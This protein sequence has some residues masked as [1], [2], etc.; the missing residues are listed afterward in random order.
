V[1]R[2]VFG[3][4]LAVATL[5]WVGPAEL[6][7]QIVA[8]ERGLVRQTIDG[9][10]IEIDYGRPSA[11]GRDRL[12]GG[13]VPWGLSWTPGANQSTTISFSKPVDLDGVPVDAG[14]YSVWVEVNE[15]PPW[16]LLLHPDTMLFH[17]AH[18]PAEE[19]SYVVD[20]AP[21]T[22][23]VFMETLLFSFPVVRA[24][25]A[26]L[27]L[28][29]GGTVLPV[30]VAVES[31]VT[32]RVSEEEGRALEGE[33]EFAGSPEDPPMRLDFAWDPASGELRGEWDQGSGAYD[34]VM[35]R[36]A[37]GIYQLGLVVGDRLGSVVEVW[38]FEFL[39]FRNG[40][41]QAFEVRDL[42]DELRF[43]GRR[44]GR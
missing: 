29:W 12:F 7:A 40:R 1:G 43:E 4:A 17:T 10:V 11:R 14:V 34:V 8:S 42:G 32:L 6:G 27:Q 23:S 41:A 33:W 39:D 37:E 24:D 16:R 38:F 36:K 21:R 19:A 44:V 25:G 20:V 5:S 30:D 26:T 18:P 2:R 22:A 15:S 35:V 3:A 31:T 28:A 13:V 9:T